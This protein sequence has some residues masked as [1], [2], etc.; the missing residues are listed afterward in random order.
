MNSLGSIRETKPRSPRTRSSAATK[1]GVRAATEMVTRENMVDTT[2]TRLFD[3]SLCAV[4]TQEVPVLY[5]CWRP[6]RLISLFGVV[7]S[8]A[9]SHAKC[10]DANENFDGF[11]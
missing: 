3:V 6:R 7:A 11:G 10:S 8:L 4:C 9:M 5:N 1:A 2:S